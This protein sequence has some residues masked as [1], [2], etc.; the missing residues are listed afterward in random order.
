MHP[1]TDRTSLSPT[2]CIADGV[3][4]SPESGA[5]VD[6]TSN[7]TYTLS[8]DGAEISEWTFKSV[9]M[10]S[11]VLPG[12]YADPNIAT[13]N[14]AYYI[15]ATTDGFDG[16]GGKDFY[17]WKSRNLVD[18][19]RSETPILT[20][21]GANGNVPWA[22][23][24]AWAP[25][26]IERSGKYYFYF[27]G[28]N[29]TYNRKTIGVAVANSPEGPF[30]AESTA[31]ILNNEAVTTGQAIDPATFWDPQSDKYY[32]FWGNGSPLFAEL[33]DD[34]V[35]IKS[36]TIQSISGLTD[37]REGIFVN[38]RNG[39]Y[40]LTYSIDDTGSENYH[41]G[42]ATSSSVNGPWTYRGVI[43]QKDP[44][45]GILATGHSSILQLPGTDEWVIC[46]HRF[47]IPNG[48]GI[49]RETT[50]DRLVFGADGLIQP[51][52]PTLTSIET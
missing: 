19:S 42:Y 49:R 18:W 52:R 44:T 34:M 35:S 41:V 29:P 45:Q 43:L 50:I 25:T 2:F 7:V 14:Q 1:G 6:L 3:A 27:S 20:L 33:N 9:E 46:Y 28:H 21:D 17:V 51:V 26:I 30:V 40:H 4:S 5:A 12:L 24:N 16:W 8:K 13:F 32:L 48:S 15:Y 23:G 31:M 22:T 36:G 38:F 10:R 47:A 39:L 11:P 37:F